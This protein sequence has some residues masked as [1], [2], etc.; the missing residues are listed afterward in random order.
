M[1]TDDKLIKLVAYFTHVCGNI[2]QQEDE[3]I[4]RHSYI[5]DQYLR[6]HLKDGPHVQVYLDPDDAGVFQT[7]SVRY[8]PRKIALA[9]IQLC[10]QWEVPYQFWLFIPGSGHAESAR[11]A[12]IANAPRPRSKLIPSRRAITHQRSG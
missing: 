1:A 7:Q 2:M 8:D 4:F 3:W 9:A 5:K 6:F 12:L 11:F 10:I